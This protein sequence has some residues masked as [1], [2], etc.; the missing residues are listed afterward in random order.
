MSFN[1]DAKKGNFRGKCIYLLM[2]IKQKNQKVWERLNLQFKKTTPDKTYD[3]YQILINEFRQLEQSGGKDLGPVE[4]EKKVSEPKYR[5]LGPEQ[6]VG[7]GEAEAE[8][9]SK[10]DK[11]KPSKKKTTKKA[12]A[13][14][15]TKKVTKKKAANKKATKKTTKSKKAASSKKSKTKKKSKKKA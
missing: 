1:N 10:E 6:K 7:E 14:K 12:K 13:T 15:K 11:E 4:V 9:I 2:L 8:K 5:I 3:F